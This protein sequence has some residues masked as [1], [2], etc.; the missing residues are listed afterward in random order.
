[1]T[2][3]IYKLKKGYKYSYSKSLVLLNSEQSVKKDAGEI[4]VVWYLLFMK[5]ES[6]Y[7]ICNF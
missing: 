4:H 3:I 6:V 1:M 5:Q 2:E 7:N